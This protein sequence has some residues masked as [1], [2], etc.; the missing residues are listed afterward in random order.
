MKLLNSY[1]ANDAPMGI[2][3]L[4]ESGLSLHIIP[5]INELKME[6]DPKHHHKDVYEHSLEV[7]RWGTTKTSH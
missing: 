2:R 6:V 5:E 7:L 3:A 1:S 4:V